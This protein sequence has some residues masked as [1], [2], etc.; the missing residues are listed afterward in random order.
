MPQMTIIRSS[1]AEG[2]STVKGDLMGTF[3]GDV[4]IDR[5]YSGERIIMANVNFIFYART[6]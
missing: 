3:I 6:Y 2:K 1:R 5:V 4:Y